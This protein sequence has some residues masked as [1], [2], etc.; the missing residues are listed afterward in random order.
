MAYINDYYYNATGFDYQGGHSQVIGDMSR[1]IDIR[2]QEKSGRLPVDIS[3]YISLDE[4]KQELNWRSVSGKSVEAEE[5]LEILKRI[6]E[7]TQGPV[8]ER[9][10]R[11]RD[12]A[13]GLGLLLRKN[14]LTKASLEEILKYL[15][16]EIEADSVPIFGGIQSRVWLHETSFEQKDIDEAHDQGYEEGYRKA[17]ETMKL[18][19]SS[20]SNRLE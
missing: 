1:N 3:R 13:E 11:L 12:V 20:P 7:L 18:A 8:D 9:W 4:I 19:Y 16:E 15:T 17:V 10:F 14:K 6:D 5:V 2:T